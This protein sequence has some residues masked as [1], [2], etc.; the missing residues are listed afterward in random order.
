LGHVVVPAAVGGES[1]GEIDLFDII[2]RRHDCLG[3]QI[4]GDEFHVVAGGAHGHGVLL[5]VE[6]D[7]Q[8]LLPRQGI[9]AGRDLTGGVELI[10]PGSHSLAHLH[11]LV[12]LSDPWTVVGGVLD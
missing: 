9:R 1:G 7:L 4:T 6:L 10:H 5:T 11:V 8:R 12:P 3:E 2:H